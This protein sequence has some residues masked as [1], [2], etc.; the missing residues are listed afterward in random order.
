MLLPHIDELAGNLVPYL[1][2]LVSAGKIAGT[3]ALKSIGHNL[4]DKANQALQDLWSWLRPEVEAR[5]ALKNAAEELALSPQSSR[6]QTELW[7]ELRRLLEN[8]EEFAKGVA[9]LLERL[10]AQGV[11]ASNLEIGMH[12]GK[13]E[14]I[15]VEDLADIR[16]S[17][18]RELRADVR[19]QE[20]NEGSSTIGVRIGRLGGPTEDATP[21]DEEWGR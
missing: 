20:T 11:V 10:A 3:E 21:A 1:P 17:G 2:Y 13:L 19:I 14:G 12:G 18:I 9:Q 4:G 15:A 7:Y 16:K 6:L 5:P 8:D